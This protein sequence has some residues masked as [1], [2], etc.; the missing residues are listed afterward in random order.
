MIDSPTLQALQDTAASTARGGIE[1]SL[2]YVQQDSDT[3]NIR[4]AAVGLMAAAV[5]VVREL[6]PSAQRDAFLKMAGE[7]W[8]GMTP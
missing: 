6:D 3:A 1:S 7:A 5:T 4:A 2:A 8:D